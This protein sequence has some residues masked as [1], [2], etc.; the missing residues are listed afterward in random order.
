MGSVQKAFSM[1][2][3]A[4]TSPESAGAAQLC[5]DDYSLLESGRLEEAQDLLLRARALG[6][7]NALIHFRLEILRLTE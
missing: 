6:P 4:N 1:T 5:E 7:N 2:E 3:M